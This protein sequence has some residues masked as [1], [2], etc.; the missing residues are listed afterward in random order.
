MI[1]ILAIA[2]TASQPVTCTLTALGDDITDQGPAGFTVACPAD[3]E[4]AAAIQSA[5]EAAIARVDLPLPHQ[6]ITSRGNRAVHE[7]AD[8]LLMERAEGGA[9]RPSLGQVLVRGVPVFPARAVENRARH[10]MC[11]LALRPAANG[12]DPAPDVQCISNHNSTFVI[13]LLTDA[14]RVSAERYRFAPADTAYCLDE[15]VS[16]ESRVIVMPGRRLE[17]PTP[18]PDPSALPNL[19]DAG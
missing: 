16:A 3:H 9:W 10:M 19:C 2:L 5:A 1:L 4:D 18:P 12:A 7:T 13:R 8:T 14:M 17:Q 6:R 11:A 15:Q